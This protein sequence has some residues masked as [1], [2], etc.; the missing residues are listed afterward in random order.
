MVPAQVAK[1]FPELGDMIDNMQANIRLWSTQQ[2]AEIEADP[3]KSAVDKAVELVRNEGREARFLT[4]LGQGYWAYGLVGRAG[5]RARGIE[6][7]CCGIRF[8]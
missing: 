4:L 5:W 1:I 7:C 8:G 3:A 6:E 2:A